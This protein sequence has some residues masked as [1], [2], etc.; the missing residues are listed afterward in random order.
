MRT[1]VRAPRPEPP[2]ADPA[3]LPDGGTLR[4]VVNGRT[5]AGW[6]QAANPLISISRKPLRPTAE[7]AIAWRGNVWRGPVDVTN[8][9]RNLVNKFL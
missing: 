8:V 9:A 1:L 7:A 5:W 2:S 3:P 4:L 6:D